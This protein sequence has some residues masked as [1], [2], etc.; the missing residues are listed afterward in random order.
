MK[1]TLIYLWQLPQN[2]LGLLMLALFRTLDDECSEFTNNGVLICFSKKMRGG[3]SLG[4]YV[5]LKP[6]VERDIH[7]ELGHCRQSKRLGWLYLPVVGIP[8]IIHAAFYK[9]NSQDPNGYYRYW[10]EAWADRLGGVRREIKT[11]IK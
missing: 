8:S 9:Y 4:R 5:F 3:V 6:T 10:C 7:H 11:G 1:K 2:L